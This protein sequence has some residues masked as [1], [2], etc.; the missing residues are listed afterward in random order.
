MAQ[1]LARG[2]PGPHS[3]DVLPEIWSR[4]RPAASQRGG[5]G[6]KSTRA[7]RRVHPARAA[8]KQLP[9]KQFARD[10]TESAP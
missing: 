6:R 3:F 7:T 10:C 8:L 2:A 1:L 9:G 4:R 5:S